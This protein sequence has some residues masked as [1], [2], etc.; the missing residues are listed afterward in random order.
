MKYGRSNSSPLWN[1]TWTDQSDW[2][3]WC[4]KVMAMLILVRGGLLA[5]ISTGH[6]LQAKHS[7]QW[8][9]RQL[10]NWARAH[11]PTSGCTNISTMK[12]IIEWSFP[13][14]IRTYLSYNR[15]MSKK[16]CRTPTHSIVYSNLHQPQ[17]MR[18]QTT[19]LDNRL[20]VKIYQ[21]AGT[22]KERN[23]LNVTNLMIQQ[24]SYRSA[25]GCG[26]AL[27]ILSCRVGSNYF[28]IVL[29]SGPGRMQNHN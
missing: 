2:V 12:K 16:N 21:N 25:S 17:T 13:G 20:T 10:N 11:V 29:I 7:D 15:I 8:S 23:Q 3:T 28:G 19:F 4:R 26:S 1:E 27:C 5:W 14:Q 22:C 24:L 9:R 6:N 18:T